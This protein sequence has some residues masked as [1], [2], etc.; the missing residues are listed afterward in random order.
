[1]RNYRNWLATCFHSAFPNP[2]NITD[3]LTDLEKRCETN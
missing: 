3:I 1:M 2:E